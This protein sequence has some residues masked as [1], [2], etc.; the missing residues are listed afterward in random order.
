MFKVGLSNIITFIFVSNT[1][2]LKSGQYFRMFCFA[3]VLMQILPKRK[4]KSCTKISISWGIYKMETE[5]FNRN[6][7]IPAVSS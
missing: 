3:R 7:M 1:Y 5:I 6:E 2:S 4:P